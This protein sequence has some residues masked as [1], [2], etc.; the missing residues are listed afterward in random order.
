[1]MDKLY[2]VMKAGDILDWFVDD[3]DA[4]TYA[5]ANDASVYTFANI[6][7]P[8]RAESTDQVSMPNWD[9]AP[10]EREA[11][12]TGFVRCV[13]L[14]DPPK[15]YIDWNHWA[16][17]PVKEG[18]TIA[19]CRPRDFHCRDSDAPDER[20]IAAQEIAG[21]LDWINYQIAETPKPQEGYSYRGGVIEGMRTAATRLS[22]ALDRLRA[23][24][25]GQDHA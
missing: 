18:A 6:S 4:R 3:V 5:L 21:A 22:D 12:E 25:E 2:V 9:N 11:Q 19:A 8:H 17:M 20:E 10:D 15:G 23:G 1:M 7:W 14:G 16:S 13:F 24:K